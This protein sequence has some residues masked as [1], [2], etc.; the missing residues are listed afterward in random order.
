M[1][2]LSRR[3]GTGLSW[4]LMQGIIA[5]GH[6]LTAEAGRYAFREGGNAFD[7]IV[8]AALMSWVCEPVLASPGGGGFA[9]VAGA[10]G[11]PVLLDGFAQ[12]PLAR[13]EDARQF[14][15]EA[16]FGPN[17]QGFYLGAGT[18]ATPGA[19]ALLEALHRRGG[20]LPWSALFAP[21]VEHARAGLKITRHAAQLF[22]VVRALYLVDAETRAVFGRESDRQAPLQEGDSWHSPQ[23]ADF[24][25]E[26]AGAGARF[27]YAGEISQ[28]VHRKME[29][30]GGHLRRADFEAYRIEQRAPLHYAF[31]EN[32]IWSNPLPSLGARYVRLGLELLGRGLAELPAADAP[33]YALALARFQQSVEAAWRELPEDAPWPADEDPYWERLRRAPRSVRG[34]THL[35]ATDEAG[36]A[37]GLTA[38]NGSGSAVLVPHAGFMLNNMLGETDLVDDPERPEAWPTDTRMASMMAPTI[39]VQPDRSV[40]VTG[41]GGSMRIRT[42][43]LQVLLHLLREGASL[44][45]AVEAPR[46]HADRTGIHLEP[47]FTEAQRQVLERAPDCPE[48]VDHAAENLFFGG[49]HSVRQ[50]GDGTLSGVGDPRRGGV[51]LRA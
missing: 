50:L 21:A 3:A 32:R 7:A 47:G 4:A 33:G 41:S 12:T 40:L 49:A 37:I 14:L 44:D 17:R 36:N 16:D 13:A 25:E 1:Q 43:L 35:S 20:R 8:A 46:L 6:P 22:E 45:A 29:A 2:R 38:S 39:V 11:P 18:V 19:V 31:G 48:L 10:S 27:F 51:C 30:A 26:L 23:L 42:T 9:L 34:T 15:L 24:L 28:L 5:A